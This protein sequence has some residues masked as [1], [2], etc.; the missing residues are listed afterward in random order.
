MS[1]IAT[2]GEYDRTFSMQVVAVAGA[3][4]DVEA[5]VLQEARDPLAQEHRVVRDDDAQ[6]LLGHGRRRPQRRVRVGQARS[7]ELVDPLGR[8]QSA[9]HVLAEVARLDRAAQLLERRLGEQHLSSVPGFAEPRGEVDVDPVVVA[10]LERRLAGVDPDP[11]ADG[12]VGP[13]V[14][15]VRVL[16][17]L[18]GADRGG[19]FVEHDRELVAAAIELA[20]SGG[21]DRG[22]HEAAVV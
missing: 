6:L 18:G 14:L 21:L 5:G 12:T 20:P 17:R 1:T 9:Q 3:A 10:V 15:R 16:D 8:R 4:D 22:S 7:E 19:R 11:H 2:S 13:G